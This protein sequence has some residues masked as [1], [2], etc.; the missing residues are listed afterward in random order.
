MR[1]NKQPDFIT[2][3]MIKYVEDIL[4][5]AKVDGTATTPANN[6]LLEEET[7]DLLD[8]SAQG[9]FHTGVAKLLYLAKRARQKKRRGR[10]RASGFAL[11]LPLLL[12]LLH[13]AYCYGNRYI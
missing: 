12:L 3:D 6:N 11:A 5:W 13:K 9:D 4:D 2:V 8:E 1:I 10:V 7:S